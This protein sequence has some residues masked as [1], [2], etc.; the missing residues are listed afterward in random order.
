M[1]APVY[2]AD[3]LEALAFT[4]EAFQYKT[5][6]STGVPYL[7]HLLAVAAMVG[8][9]GGDEEQQI[10]ALLHDYLEDIPGASADVL[11]HRFGRR[12]RE[13]VEALSDCEG[14]PKPPWRDRKRTYIA[15]LRTKSPAVKLIS[16][17]D[18]VH[19]CTSLLRDYAT[20]GEQVFDCFNAKRAGTLWYYRAL[21]DAL[22]HGGWHHYLLDELIAVVRELHD[23]AGALPLLHDLTFPDSLD[24]TP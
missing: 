24:K 17:A 16:A 19:N 1:G 21:P 15:Q 4:A 5:R 12:V 22:A 8:E 10:A 9:G 18:K 11:E 23:R 14:H 13:M 6:K 7:T 20:K 2:S 3:Y